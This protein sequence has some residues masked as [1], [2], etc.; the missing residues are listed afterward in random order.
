MISNALNMTTVLAAPTGR[1]AKRMTETTGQEALTLHRLLEYDPVSGYKRDEENPIEADAI[2]IDETSMVDISLFA[3]LL[4][5]VKDGTRIVF[6]GDADQLPS[7]GPGNVLNDL[8]K[9]GL[10]NVV[11]LDQIHRQQ[12]GS[13]ISKNAR[14]INRG[15]IPVIDN[16]S[17]FMFVRKSD[18]QVALETL[19]DVVSSR[20]PDR[21]GFDRLKDIQVLSPIK[22]GLLGT[23]NL[24]KEL[25]QTLNPPMP[26]KEEMQVGDQIFRE[27]DKVM[28]MKNNYQIS[29]ED[30]T[31]SGEGV[32]N[33][34]IGVITEI[35]DGEVN[36]HFSDDKVAVFTEDTVSQLS[37]AYCSTIHKAQGSEFPGVVLALA[38][39]RMPF[40]NRRLLY[41]GV[42]RAKKKLFMIGKEDTFRHMVLNQ[43]DAKRASLLAQ[44]IKNY[45]EIGI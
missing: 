36:V 7:V 28:Q 29:W 32:F 10:V 13:E 14:E 1:A 15:I 40:N 24:N 33:G 39:G 18:D 21:F 19:L 22:K 16:Q 6:V 35:R 2:I 25:Q 17:D 41:T 3:R 30:N 23:E 37:L 42:T 31:T 12:E 43:T 27:G 26:Y 45:H 38:G 20:M 4:D 9:T 8:I 34:D 44:R 11:T 5:A